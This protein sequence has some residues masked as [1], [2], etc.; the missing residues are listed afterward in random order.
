LP[1]APVRL[2]MTFWGSRLRRPEPRIELTTQKRTLPREDDV[3]LL[4]D[5]FL[6]LSVG[7]TYSF[8][9]APEDG[10]KFISMGSRS[11]TTAEIT[12]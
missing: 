10:S 8:S 5:G 9:L 12:A 4:F 2:L 11:W 3:T 1:E 6:N 7:G